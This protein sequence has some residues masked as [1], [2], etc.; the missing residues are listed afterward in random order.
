MKMHPIFGVAILTMTAGP[1]NAATLFGVDETN[2]LLSFD[3][4]ALGTFTSSIQITGTGATMLALDFR[5]AN[6]WLYGFGDDLRLYRIDALTAAATAISAAPLAVVGSNFGFDF[7]P[8]IDRIRLVSNLGNNYVLNPNDG[9]LQLTATPISYAAGDPT[10][11][12]GIA[13]SVTASAYTPSFFGAPSSSTQL[14]ALDNA[15]DVLARQGNNSG[16]LTTVGSIGVNFGPRDSFD[17]DALGTGYVIDNTRLYTIDLD[18]GA[19][20][21]L[22]NTSRTV[23]GLSASPVS[24]PPVPEPASWALMI[25]GFGLIGAAM[26]GGRRARTTFA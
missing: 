23:Y 20:S 5:P 15:N 24:A 12:S 17:I 21:F 25:A 6:G 7:N 10:A 8:A 14:Y 13:P 1:L 22:G 3:S 11:S 26:R 4:S 19:L 16:V 9:S 18:T 2:N